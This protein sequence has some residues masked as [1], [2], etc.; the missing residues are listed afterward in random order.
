M[1]DYE[2][3]IEGNAK[4]ARLISK[5]RQLRL[6]YSAKLGRTVTIEEVAEAAGL[7]RAALSRIELNQTERIDFDTITKL[8]AYYGVGVGDLLTLEEETQPNKGRPMYAAA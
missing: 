8:C 6:E 4:M 5:A 3:R 1:L 7:T 2:R